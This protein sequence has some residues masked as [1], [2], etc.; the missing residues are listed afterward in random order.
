ME[1]QG[2]GSSQSPAATPKEHAPNGTHSFPGVFPGAATPGETGNEQGRRE[3]PGSGLG[4]A[5]PAAMSRGGETAVS[6]PMG[7]VAA[8]GGSRGSGGPI[9][10]ICHEGD[11]EG[12]LISPC[13]C[14]GSVALVHRQ[15]LERWLN[16][17]TCDTCEL[18][19]YR[20]PLV[21]SARPFWQFL[22]KCDNSEARRAC[23]V[24]LIC[25][26]LL[27]PIAMLSVYLC[28]IGALQYSQEN[29]VSFAV[30]TEG[31]ARIQRRGRD[32]EGDPRVLTKQW[33]PVVLV[34]GAMFLVIIYCCWAS[35][36]LK[37]HMRL[38]R[39]WRVVNQDVALAHRRP[40]TQPHTQPGAG[41]RL[42]PHP[43]Q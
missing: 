32:Q 4:A 1:S 24:D 14:A 31:P 23:K 8:S 16:T 26:F 5:S 22:I 18:C 37:Y 43:G 10:R 30:F 27:T 40:H 21:R 33:E 6:L 11:A 9:C 7:A 20:F 13:W 38:W 42:D 12:E 36:T 25:L 19:G 3:G 2:Q 28:I 15:C 29:Q 17:A 35:L 34:G 39:Q 41:G